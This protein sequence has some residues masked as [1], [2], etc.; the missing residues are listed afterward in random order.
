MDLMSALKIYV[1]VIPTVVVLVGL[2]ALYLIDNIQE[3]L[4]MLKAF[5]WFTLAYVIEMIR[6]SLK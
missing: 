1:L 4:V 2:V 6:L 3:V 5:G